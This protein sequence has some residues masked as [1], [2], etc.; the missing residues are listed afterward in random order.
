MALAC[1]VLGYFKKIICADFAPLLLIIDLNKKFETF[2][3]LHIRAC[4]LFVESS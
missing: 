1:H 4:K 2:K 3:N